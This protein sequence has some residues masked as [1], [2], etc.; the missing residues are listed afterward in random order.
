MQEY[1]RTPQAAAGRERGSAEGRP[2]EARLVQELQGAPA[3]T[4]DER[5]RVAERPQPPP[6]SSSPEPPLPPPPTSSPTPPEAGAVP[7]SRQ[8]EGEEGEG[9]AGPQEHQPVFDAREVRDAAHAL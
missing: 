7:S 9:D 5:R 3:G 1:L 8:R 6:L 4:E 2:Q